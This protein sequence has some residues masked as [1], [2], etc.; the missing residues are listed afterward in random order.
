MISSSRRGSEQKS[1]A[2]FESLFVIRVQATNPQLGSRGDLR[3]LHPKRGT[4]FYKHTPSLIFSITTTAALHADHV[5]QGRNPP[6]RGA[7]VAGTS[8]VRL[9]KR[10][11]ISAPSSVLHFPLITFE[12]FFCCGGGDSGE[13][14]LRA[15]C[16]TLF[17][18]TAACLGHIEHMFDFMTASA[19]P[20]ENIIAFGFMGFGGKRCCRRRRRSPIYGVSDSFQTSSVSRFS[21]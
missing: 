7:A 10:R 21:Q 16:F 1:G 6:P 11:L 20:P 3:A 5:S 17:D 12:R 19:V 15:P 2:D 14:V 13:V 4:H 9:I 8:V 18:F